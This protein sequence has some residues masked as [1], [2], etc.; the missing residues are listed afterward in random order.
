LL[1]PVRVI[2]LADRE[3]S[4]SFDASLSP[5]FSSASFRIRMTVVFLQT[6]PEVSPFPLLVFFG[7]QSFFFRARFS[8]FASAADRRTPHSPIRLLFVPPFS[9]RSGER[10]TPRLEVL[11]SKPPVLQSLL[12]PARDVFPPCQNSSRRPTL[13]SL[14][15]TPRC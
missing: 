6:L 3:I 11:R 2:F 7:L 14:G 13:S 10:N 4:F 1:P 5:R 12:I 15:M 9:L 8:I